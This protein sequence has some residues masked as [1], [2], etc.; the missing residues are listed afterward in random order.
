MKKEAFK[1]FYRYLGKLFFPEN[2]TCDCCGAELVFP[3]RYNLCSKCMADTVFAEGKVC[4]SCGV[5]LDNEADYCLNCSGKGRGLV[6]NRSAVVYKGTAVKL[7]GALKF[8]GKRYIARL[9][10]AMLADR[11]LDA[12]T[13][14]DALC[15]VPMTAKEEKA[16]GFNQAELIAKNLADRLNI[17]LCDCLVKI[18]ETAFQKELSGKERREN[19][20]GAFAVKPGV[21]LSGKKIV[22]VDDVF[23][24][25]ATADACAS[26][27]KKAR[28]AEISS[29][30]FA[31]TAY[32]SYGETE[33]KPQ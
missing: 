30:T 19:L 13:A 27:L 8:G 24:T 10:G 6:F 12:G 15:F 7:I 29:L 31:V 16:R 14:A 32:Q 21:S 1:K 3:T 22:L 9:M 18:R 11:F 4:K 33:E 20:K 17:P 26:A 2:L 5:P 28:A 23:T 25:G